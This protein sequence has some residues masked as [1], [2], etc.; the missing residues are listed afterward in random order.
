MLVPRTWI[1]NRA[2]KFIA[3]LGH[4]R[5][6][7]RCD[8]EPSIEALARVSHKLVKKEAR[9]CQRDHQWERA[10]LTESSN[11]VGLAHRIGVKVPSDARIVCCLVEF[12]ASLRCDISSDGKTPLHRMHGRKNNTPILEFGDKVLYMLVKA[13]RGAFVGMLN[14]LS[15]AVV[16]TEQGLA[17]KARAANVRR[18]LES[19]RWDTE[20]HSE[21]EQFCGLQMAVTTRSTFKSEWRGSRR[22][23]LVPR[24]SADG[25]QS[26]EDVPSQSRFR[27]VGSQ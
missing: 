6:T 4:N 15:E 24:R 7:Q 19:E 14:P 10:S 12:P 25:E 3:Q 9:L 11:T 1:A 2:A 22:W 27:S 18:V 5:V 16:L 26:G 20:E 17:I 21:C 13:A 23:Y 8:N